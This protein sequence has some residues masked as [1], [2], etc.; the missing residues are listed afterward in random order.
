MQKN[1]QQTYTHKKFLSPRKSQTNLG[2]LW[3]GTKVKNQILKP[4]M[5]LVALFKKLKV[6]G[7]LCQKLGS[8]TNDT[9][10]IISQMSKQKRKCNAG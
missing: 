3:S 5:L 7:A 2:A 9:F 8:E 10:S 6:S 1:K 4:K